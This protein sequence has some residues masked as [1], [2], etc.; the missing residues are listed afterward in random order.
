MENLDELLQTVALMGTENTDEFFD[1]AQRNRK[2]GK[3][4]NMKGAILI[5][6]YVPVS[7]HCLETELT[8]H[9]RVTEGAAVAAPSPAKPSASDRFGTLSSRFLNR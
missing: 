8:R 3:V 1:V 7:D 6:K 4:D 5:E 2:Y 9:F